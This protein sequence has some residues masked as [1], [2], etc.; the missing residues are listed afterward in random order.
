M[1]ASTYT[2][3]GCSSS[4]L[5]LG[6]GAAEGLSSMHD[7]ALCGTSQRP[8]L[9]ARGRGGGVIIKMDRTSDHLLR[10]WTWILTAAIDGSVF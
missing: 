1:V 8:R 7:T 9:A 6:S 3:S 4:A 10:P 5:S 2:S